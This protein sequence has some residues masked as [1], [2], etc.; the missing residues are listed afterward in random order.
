[1]T[2]TTPDVDTIEH[3]DFDHDQACRSV[4]LTA[5]DECG[6]VP[7][8]HR[9]VGDWVCPHEQVILLC[10]ECAARLIEICGSGTTGGCSRCPAT[11][12]VQVLPL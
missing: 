5:P 3:L 2:I 9:L 6:A 11:G 8:T 4:I 10:R 1:V 12:H 7:V